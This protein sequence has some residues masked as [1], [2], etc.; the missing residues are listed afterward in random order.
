MRERKSLSDFCSP[1]NRQ[2]TLGCLSRIASQAC[3]PRTRSTLIVSSGLQAN[4]IPRHAHTTL[5]VTGVSNRHNFHLAL[6]GLGSQRRR[7]RPRQN[8]QALPEANLAVLGM[9]RQLEPVLTRLNCLPATGLTDNDDDVT[10]ER[11]KHSMQYNKAPLG[12]SPSSFMTSWQ[13]LSAHSST[14]LRVVPL[15]RP[16]LA[17]LQQQGNQS[18]LLLDPSL[19]RALSSQDSHS[20][21]EAGCNTLIFHFL[22]DQQQAAHIFPLRRFRSVY[23]TDRSAP[24]KG[25]TLVKRRTHHN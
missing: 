18:V 15:D 8:R 24:T 4:E 9:S 23:V 19:L 3:R 7:S 22:L 2:Q 1:H 10:G 14:W 13:N 6:P 16:A 17:H 21:N 20:V 5:S 25:Y 11:T 12:P